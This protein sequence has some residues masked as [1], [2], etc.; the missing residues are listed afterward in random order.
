MGST[1]CISWARAARASSLAWA[2]LTDG[3]PPRP[4]SRLRPFR[5]N[6]KTQLREPQP[7]T[8]MPRPVTSPTNVIP[9]R[10]ICDTASAP[11]AFSFLPIDSPI[12]IAETRC[13]EGLCGGWAKFCLERNQDGNLILSDTSWL[14]GKRL[15]EALLLKNASRMRKKA[16]CQRSGSILDYRRED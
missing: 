2:R 14:C 12:E 4:K 6:L 1:P 10:R 13:Q 16:I 9:R 5:V 15:S 8:I 11:S 7:V 3:Y